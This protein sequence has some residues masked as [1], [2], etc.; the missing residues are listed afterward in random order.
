MPPTAHRGIPITTRGPFA[1]TAGPFPRSSGS[2]S[3]YVAEIEALI[4][5]AE[6]PRRRIACAMAGD[7][8]DQAI[9]RASRYA[10]RQLGRA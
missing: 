2:S 9:R 1:A 5:S 7:T 8:E 4:P 3:Y 6:G 10:D